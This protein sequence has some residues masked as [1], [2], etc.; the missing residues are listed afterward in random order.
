MFNFIMK[1]VFFLKLLRWLFT[2]LVKHNDILCI[3]LYYL[4]IIDNLI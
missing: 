3:L 1:N 2:I 4:K